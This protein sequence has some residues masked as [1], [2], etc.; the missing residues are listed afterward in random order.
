MG[1]NYNFNY[2]DELNTT[3]YQEKK[4]QNYKSE[5]K[6]IVDRINNGI[7]L[8]FQPDKVVGTA[9]GG[10]TDKKGNYIE[11]SGQRIVGAEMNHGYECTVHEHSNQTVIWFGVFHAHWGHFLNEMV[12]RCWYFIHQIKDI[13]SVNVAYI[14]KVDSCE[15]PIYGNYLEFLTL[16]GINR[17]NIIE[18]T[19]PTQ[20]EQ[21]I[22]PELSCRAGDFYTKEFADIFNT[23]RDNVQEKVRYHNNIYFTRLQSKNLRSTELGEKRI[24]KL[25]EKNGYEVLAP[26]HC[27]LR[28]QISYIKNCDQMVVVSGTLPHNILFARDGIEI[29][30]INRTGEVNS[31]QPLINQLRRANVTYI[32]SHLSLLPV[33]AG[34]PFLLYMSD[35]IVRYAEEHHLKLPGKKESIISLHIKLAWY[36]YCYLDSMT[37]STIRHWKLDEKFG[38]Y[39][40]NTYAFYRDRIP[41]Y[42]KKYVRRL[43]N[44]FYVLARMCE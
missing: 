20:F 12:A 42:D 41:E 13:E 31:Y 30:I 10:V 6:L 29:I 9:G 24:K 2:L 35:N 17:E 18:V 23:I 4:E 27:T 38:S 32:D 11:L 33:F 14:R 1:A 28:E 40:M 26:E 43:R 16:L 19:E 22:I 8:P 5:K 15:Q 39:I 25:F 36:F 3:A 44:C 21:V 37:G 7:I 34:G